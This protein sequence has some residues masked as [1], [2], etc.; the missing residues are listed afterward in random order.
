MLW[1]CVCSALPCNAMQGKKIKGE[2]MGFNIELIKIKNVEINE[3]YYPRDNI[4]GNWA[5]IETYYNAMKT[6]SIFPPI[7]VAKIKGKMYL[8]DGL[9]RL[10]ASIKKGEKLIQAE[11]LEG[12]T[13]SEVYQEA[14]KRNVSHGKSLTYYEKLKAIQR[15]K[16]FG[17][18][19]KKIESI[20]QMPI[21]LIK[22]QLPQRLVINSS[23]N[24]VV[25]KK[26]FE[27]FVKSG[28]IVDS[29]FEDDQKGYSGKSQFQ[30]VEQVNGLF[31][32]NFIDKNDKLVIR[33]LKKLLKNLNKFFELN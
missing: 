25:V 16:E 19:M 27:H 13:F 23:G 28:E 15:L 31:K 10:K 8:V 7:V 18:E 22:K 14:V 2:K 29:N 32:K 20:V 5:T 11:I 9:H 6:G 30:M 3:K 26:P 12:L 4:E 17:L 1:L 21:Q 33:E 24:T